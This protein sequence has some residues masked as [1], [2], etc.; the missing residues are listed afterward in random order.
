MYDRN[1]DVSRALALAGCATTQDNVIFSVRVPSQAIACNRTIHPLHER[2]FADQESF[3]TYLPELI[4]VGH[5][6]GHLMNETYIRIVNALRL[7]M[8]G[9]T[10]ALSLRSEYRDRVIEEL[11]VVIRELAGNAMRASDRVDIVA[12]GTQNK[13]VVVRV[14]D[15]GGGPPPEMIDRWATIASELQQEIVRNGI[16]RAIE[17]VGGKCRRAIGYVPP[18]SQLTSASPEEQGKPFRGNG[19]TNNISL[20]NLR[21]GHQVVPPECTSMILFSELEARNGQRISLEGKHMD[22]QFCAAAYAPIQE[23][24]NETT[25][26]DDF[27]SSF[28]F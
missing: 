9:M 1:L 10:R 11:F 17:N 2:C 6:F 3:E 27:F 24:V 7:H 19:T 16:Q 15:Q 14:I 13:G 21:I 8:S 23:R 20:F 5:Q 4:Q 26:M 22:S 18:A 12:Q 28:E 25:A